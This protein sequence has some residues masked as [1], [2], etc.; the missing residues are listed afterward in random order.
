MGATAEGELI[1]FAGRTTR[2]IARPI[3][4]DTAALEREARL[5]RTSAAAERLR[6]ALGEHTLVL[7]VERMDY[8]KGILE[9]L[10]GLEYLLEQKPEWR[11]KF[12]LIQIVTPSRLEVDAYQQKKREIDEAVGR[13]NGRFSDGIWI[14]HPRPAHDRLRRPSCWPITAPRIS[15]WSPRCATG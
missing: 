13:I 10:R 9:R 5:A 8:T 15:R 7:G 11:G 1:R 3:G 6:S 4:I 12:T 14:P 2:V